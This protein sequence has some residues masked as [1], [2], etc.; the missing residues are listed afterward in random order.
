MSTENNSVTLQNTISNS[1]TVPF[2]RDFYQKRCIAINKNNKK[3]RV[4]TNNNSFFCCKSH[5]P[6]NKELLEDGCFLCMEKIEKV[7]DLI[8]FN[9]KHIIHKTCYK[10][11]LKYST[12][13]E[14]ICLLCRNIVF[15]KK[16]NIDSKKCKSSPR[17][18]IDTT[19]IQ[20][21]NSTLYSNIEK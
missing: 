5:E 15:E 14:N 1:S 17:S 19:P 11:W 10:E 6:I 2:F 3:C 13:D 21:I 16:D 20:L 8:Y 4:K 9:C 18:V 12:Y 7:N